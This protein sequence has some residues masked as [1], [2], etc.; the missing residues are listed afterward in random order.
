MPARI[1]AE[2]RRHIVIEAAFR[3]IVAEG[4]EGLTLRKVAVEAELNIGSVRHFF[5][6]HEDLLAAAA[7]EAGNRM[8]RRLAQHPVEQLRGLT[9]EEALNALQNFLEQVLPLDEPRKEEAI[10]VLEFIRASRTQ[11]VFASSAAQMASDLHDVITDALAC[12]GVPGP[13]AVARQISALIG[14]LTL[15]T[16]TPHGA[17][18]VNQLRSTLRGALGNLLVIDADR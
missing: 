18:T 4:L 15:D 13:S 9:G 11:P 6:G 3:M 2:E 10:V 14:G 7:Q 12:L 1:D 8:G 16:V 5:N 17:L